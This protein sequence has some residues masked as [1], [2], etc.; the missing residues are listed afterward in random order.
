MKVISGCHN[1]RSQ[2]GAILTIGNFDGL[3]LGH[4]RLIDRVLQLAGSYHKPSVLL[5]FDPHPL[6]ILY[7]DKN[8]LRLCSLGTTKELLSRTGLDTLVVEPFTTAFSKLPPE[9]FIEEMIIPYIK[10]AIIV[11]GHDFRFGA[12]S[13]GSYK[14]LDLLADKYGFKVEKVPVVKEEDYIVS[15]SLIKELM[16]S[17]KWDLIPKLLGR[18][19]SIKG[20][21]VKGRGRGKKIGIPTINLVVDKEQLIPI[22]GVYISLVR[23]KNQLFQSVM[24]I[25]FNP[26]VSQDCTT[27]IEVHLI[28][29]EIQWTDSS[30]EVE[31]LSYLRPEIRF[32]GLSVLVNQIKKDIAEAKK[33]FKITDSFTD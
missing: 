31:V 15:S 19:F 26:T 22:N 5:T 25:G 8:H 9:K 21:V 24:N 20:Q 10:P 33:Y 17:G 11:I 23:Q 29:K 14:L 6:R 28:D 27:K 30:C 16:L 18:S 1:Y 12:K 2:A 13:K 3:H 4:Q 7:P 32:S